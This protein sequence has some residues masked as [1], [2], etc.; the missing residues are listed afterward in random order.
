MTDLIIGKTNVTTL[1]KE[2]YK[3]LGKGW[4]TLIEVP[5]DK[6]MKINSEAI[7]VLV[8]E[9][10]YTCIY[11]TLT[12]PFTEL[13]KLFKSNGINSDNLYYIDAI[14]KMYGEDEE[15]TKKCIYTSGP[16]DIDSLSV[17]VKSLL[18]SIQ[19]EK[20]CVFLDSVTTVLLYNSMPRTIRFSKFLTQTLKS[21]GVDGVM[22]SI[23]KGEATKKLSNELKKLS[24]E[25]ISISGGGER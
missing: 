6:H 24:D 4:L 7:R 22:V 11:I 16:L 19:S 17:S 12:K 9:L 5:S 8:N 1:L 13:D 25:F 23:A 2:K 20:K 3:K 21:V 15:D 18:S 14:S 10:N